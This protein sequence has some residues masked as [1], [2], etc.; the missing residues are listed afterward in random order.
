MPEY[1]LI[2]FKA[3]AHLAQTAAEF[4]LEQLHVDAEKILSSGVCPRTA[5]AALR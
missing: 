2:G 5:T 1:K 4:G 3:Q